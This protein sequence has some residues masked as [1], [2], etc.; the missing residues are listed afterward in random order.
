[1]KQIW[2]CAGS[3]LLAS[4]LIAPAAV[5]PKPSNSSCM[6]G[7][8]VPASYTWNFN[9]E[10]DQLLTQM[11]HDA[12]K[13]RMAADDLQ[14][15]TNTPMVSWESHAWDLR[16]IRD[17]VNAMGAKLCRLEMI[18]RVV[19]P[20]DQQEIDRTAY[21]TRLLADNVE[22]AI[23]FLNHHQHELWNP[24]YLTNAS[25]IE[26]E[27]TRLSRALTHLKEYA[28]ARGEVKDLSG[29]LGVSVGG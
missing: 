19:R 6:A 28:N 2:L 7:A 9:K 29:T 23:L 13:I 25:N 1:M 26:K 15:L 20:I 17:E 4:A 5:L 10:A 18:R 21:T 3:I 8:P 16:V 12:M 11:R 27:S 22:D 14:V 24:E